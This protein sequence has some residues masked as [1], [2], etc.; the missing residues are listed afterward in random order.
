MQ[1]LRLVADQFVGKYA[2]FLDIQIS[3]YFS[4]LFATKLAMIFIQ[5][6]FI[7]FNMNYISALRLF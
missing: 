6:F 2:F 3:F 4:F 5:I 1:R 7:C